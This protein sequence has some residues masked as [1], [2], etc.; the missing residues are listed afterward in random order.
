MK[1]RCG[2]M[3]M[4]SL[5]HPSPLYGWTVSRVWWRPWRYNL[6]VYYVGYSPNNSEEVHRHLTYDGLVGTLKL[7]ELWED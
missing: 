3:Y 5:D 2:D 4:V 6:R 1:I 7:M